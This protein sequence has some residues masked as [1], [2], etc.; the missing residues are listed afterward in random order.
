MVMIMLTLALHRAADWAKCV[1]SLAALGD[2]P[3]TARLVNVAT[4]LAKYSGKSITHSSESSEAKQEGAYR[5][6][7]NPH[8][9]AAAIRKVGAMRTV[10]LAQPFPELL[11]IEDT[12]SLS[13][14]HRVAEELGKLG[15]T[16]DKSRWWWVHSLPLLEAATFRTV[17]LLH[18]EWWMR[19]DDPAD[20][21]EKESGKW[22]AAA[23]CRQRI[24]HCSSEVQAKQLLAVL[25]ERFSECGLELHPGKTRIAYCKDGKRKVGI[26]TPASTFW[27]ISSGREWSKIAS[28][29]AYLSTSPQ[30]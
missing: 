3:R 18:Q 27:D 10:E 26:N 17:G 9:S 25:E 2:P 22:L 12:T 7:S 28:E 8:V 4:Q 23:S 24:V 6:I 13:Y 21:V 20:A 5:F 16:E 15:A 29:T 30:R 1:F 19:P 11:A 14:R